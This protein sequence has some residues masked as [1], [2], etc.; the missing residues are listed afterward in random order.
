MKILVIG[1]NG[2]IGSNIYRYLTA[3]N[4]NVFG[5]DIHILNPNTFLLKQD[6]SNILQLFNEQHYNICINASGSSTVRFSITNE[7]ED[8]QLNYLNVKKI[9]EVIIQLQPGC[10]FINLSSA[11]VYGNP[12]SLPIKENDDTL[13]IS[14]YGKHKLLS[15]ELLFNENLKNRLS[16]ISLRIF[17]VYGNTLKKQLFWDIYQKSKHSNE[18]ELYGIGNETRDFIHIDDLM[19]AIEII[20]LN[21]KFDGTTINVASGND[22]TINDAANTLINYIKP[23][24]KIIFTGQTFDADPKFWKADISKLN[25]LGFSAKVTLTSGLKNYAQWLQELN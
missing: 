23:N 3:K 4:Y 20:I 8:Y 5:A 9:I 6:L 1:C 18:I 25:K 7:Q 15:E 17:S 10:K 21:A 14:P 19:L 13:P 16:T 24:C 2:F 11:A 22:V 12:K